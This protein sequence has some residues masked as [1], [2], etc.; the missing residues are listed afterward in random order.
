MYIRCGGKFAPFFCA[1]V[2]CLQVKIFQINLKENQILQI[3]YD[4]WKQI[5][6]NILAVLL[7]AVL[8]LYSQPTREG[9][10]QTSC[11]RRRR[12]VGVDPIISPKIHPRFQQLFTPSLPL[13]T[14]VIQWF[15]G[16]GPSPSDGAKSFSQLANHHIWFVCHQDCLWGGERGEISNNWALN[17]SHLV[18]WNWCGPTENSG[19]YQTSLTLFWTPFNFEKFGKYLFRLSWVN[20]KTLLKIPQVVKFTIT[21]P[22]TRQSTSLQTCCDYPSNQNGDKIFDTFWPQNQETGQ[23]S[24]PKARADPKK[25]FN[26]SYL[27]KSQKYGRKHQDLHF[28]S[29]Q[30]NLVQH[31]KT[32]VAKAILSIS[33]GLC[34]N[35]CFLHSFNKSLV[36]A[37]Q[38]IC[39][40]L[41]H[42]LSWKQVSWYTN[43]GKLNSSRYNLSWFWT[44]IGAL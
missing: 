33:L 29:T 19:Q 11:Q 4:I 44:V 5:D 42:K 22:L 6:T 26:H 28:Q 32:P 41:S 24:T 8:G 30:E 27:L 3:W 2:T 38:T 34:F 10:P 17:V 18:I 43:F 14:I 23:F 37:G 25:M 35:P 16:Q 15:A 39:C 20:Q 9:V 12:Q 36:K 31:V 13:V 40:F 7:R 1:N 21:F